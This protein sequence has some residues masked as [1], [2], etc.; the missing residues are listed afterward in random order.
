MSAR[1]ILFAALLLAWAA[2]AHAQQPFPF[3]LPLPPMPQGSPEE[4]A[5]CQPDV[6]RFCE[7]VLPDTQRVLECLQ[8]N[9]RRISTACR[10]VLEKYGQ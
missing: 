6:Q 8:A 4:R 2:P 3:P 7:H 10:R 5:A 9:R 1:T